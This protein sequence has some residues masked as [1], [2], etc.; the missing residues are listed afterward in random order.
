MAE[1]MARR[2]PPSCPFPIVG[3]L[4]RRIEH[5][6]AGGPD[7]GSGAI[8]ADERED[9]VIGNGKLAVIDR[10]FAAMRRGDVFVWHVS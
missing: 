6:L 3:L 1:S 5:T 2:N 4:H 10:D 7:I 9:G 8:A